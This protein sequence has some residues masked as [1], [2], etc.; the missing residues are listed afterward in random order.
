MSYMIGFTFHY[1]LI[2]T[3]TTTTTEKTTVVFTF[4]Y[5]LIITCP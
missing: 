2:I 4:H 3:K 1:E 5:E